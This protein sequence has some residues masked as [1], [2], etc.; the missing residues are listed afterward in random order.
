MAMGLM[1]QLVAVLSPRTETGGKMT[2]VW[3]EAQIAQLSQKYRIHDRGWGYHFPRESFLE[4]GYHPPGG[5]VK[6][7]SLLFYEN[8]WHLFHI[9]GRPGEV[10]WI[11]GNEISFGHASTADFRHWV[12]HQMPLAVGD[13][14]WESEHIWAPFVCRRGELFYLFYMGS[15][16]GE[17]F[18]TYATSSDLEQWQRREAGPIREAVGRDPFV[19]EHDGRVVLLYTA[20][21]GARI[22]ACVSDDMTC[23]EPLPDAL[24]IPARTA[25][26]SCSLH[27]LGGGDYVLWFNDFA[28]S[29]PGD[30]WPGDF[31]CRY[32][33]SRDPL[34][35][36]ADQ[37]RPFTFET[38]VT[39]EEDTHPRF[40]SRPGPIGLKLIAGGEDVW[41]VA[42]FRWHTGRYRLFF[43]ALDWSTSP[44]ATVREIRTS[45]S[46]D[47]TL[48]CVGRKRT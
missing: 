17:T 19:F 21:G 48:Q 4:H 47:E 1:A 22:G 5:Y 34:Y 6:D 7:F 46:L 39:E 45:E 42:Y 31:G 11:T 38:D 10:C 13:R 29:S 15:G 36:E 37:I 30:T 32:A 9:D 8:R 33:L 44:A 25:A 18:I 24:T 43:G 27:R 26:E 41:L 23:W 14:S 3:T 40:Q 35:F 28:K 20:H 2:D 16:R 12:R